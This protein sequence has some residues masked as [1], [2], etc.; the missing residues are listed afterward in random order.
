MVPPAVGQAFNTLAFAIILYP[1]HSSLI[2]PNRSV[3]EAHMHGSRSI[4][5]GCQHSG[6]GLHEMDTLFPHPF[7]DG[8]MNA[9][10]GKRASPSLRGLQSTWVSKPQ[11]LSTLCGKDSFLFAL[12]RNHCPNGLLY[13]W[14]WFEHLCSLTSLSQRSLVRHSSSSEME[15]YSK[16]AIKTQSLKT[17]DSA[18]PSLGMQ[19]LEI[20]GRII[21]NCTFQ[22]DFSDLCIVGGERNKRKQWMSVIGK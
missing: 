12:L 22:N 1:N 10:K 4:A 20:K 7:Q 6:L 13:L 17:F 16:V 18:F 14:L 9:Q 15:N 8:Q 5:L 11:G 21:E 3:K 2:M 19:L